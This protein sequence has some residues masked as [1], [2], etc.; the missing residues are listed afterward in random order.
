[1]NFVY[2]QCM[3][4]HETLEIF[5]P[6]WWQSNGITLA[7]IIVFLLLGRWANSENREKLAKFIGVVLI[8][9]TIGVHFYWDYLGIWKIESSLPL[10]LCGLSAILSGIVIFWRKQ[11]AYECLYFWGLPGAFHSLMTPEFTIGTD[12]FLFYEYYLSH[13]GIILSAIY[14]TWILGMRPRRGSWWKV[15]LGSQ[16]L[17]PIIGL[18]NWPLDANYMY[19]CI[20]PI[21]KNPFLIGEWPWYLLGIECAAILHF[22]VIYLP[23]AYLYH[24]A[25]V[26]EQ[27]KVVSV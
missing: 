27:D 22:F 25:E 7:F 1:M 20:K 8:I 18:I 19:L 2:W 9:R 14:L 4:P 21:A 13:G 26:N 16:L 17:V 24:Q 5:S 12:G 23:I 11:W 10:H 15:F 3:I 6:F